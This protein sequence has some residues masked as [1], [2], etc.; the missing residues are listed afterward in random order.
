MKPKNSE[1]LVPNRKKHTVFPPFSPHDTLLSYRSFENGSITIEISI[2]PKE[3]PAEHACHDRACEIPSKVEPK[4]SPNNGCC[5]HKS[6]IDCDEDAVGGPPPGKIFK[7]STNHTNVSN[8][9]NLPNSNSQ[10]NVQHFY[11]LNQEEELID[12]EELGDR[13][14]QAGFVEISFFCRNGNFR[15]ENMAF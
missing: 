14:V 12:V 7:K 3:A 8:L 13:K 2:K 10:K 9:P 6:T 11:E 4:S 1:I 5:K 15:V